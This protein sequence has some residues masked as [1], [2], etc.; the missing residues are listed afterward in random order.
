MEGYLAL[1]LHAHLPYVRH[2]DYEDFLE[3]NWLFEAITETYVPLFLVIDG[4]LEDGIDFRLTFSLTPTLASMLLDPLLQARY[5]KKLERTIELAAKEVTRTASIPDY[6]P[7]ALMYHRLFLQV[8][9]AFVNRYGKNL[10]RGMDRFRQTGNVEVI[11][12][13]AT[14]AYLPLLSVNES[15][16]R[17]QI[18]LGVEHYR[19]TFGQ[20]P[21]GFWLPECGYYPGIDS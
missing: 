17:A 5:L 21:K 16:V 4:L 3:E 8:H 13:A 6:Q 1:V 10:V 18:A 2:P 7:L 11:A 15:A 9:D 12:S 14:H 19:Q 20:P